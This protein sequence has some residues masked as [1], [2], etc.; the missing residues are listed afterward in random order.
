MVTLT[1]ALIS[2]LVG[3]DGQHHNHFTPREREPIP[4]LQEAGGP[5][6]RSRQV[7]EASHLQGFELWTV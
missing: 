4:I 6:G 2:A 3:V 1:V 7:Q 5:Q